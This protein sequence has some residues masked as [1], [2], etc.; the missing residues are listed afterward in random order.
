M[1]FIVNIL[2]GL[3]TKHSLALQGKFLEMKEE[4]FKIL[5]D[6]LCLFFKCYLNMKLHEIYL[7]NS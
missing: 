5:Q 6:F 7:N 3:P 1:Q 2:N 4:C